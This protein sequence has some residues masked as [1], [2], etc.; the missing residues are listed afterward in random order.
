MKD[1]ILNVISWIP[2]VN[3]CLFITDLHMEPFSEADRRNDHIFISNMGLVAVC[4][5]TFAILISVGG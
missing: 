3:C 4:V 5:I 2:M 1:K